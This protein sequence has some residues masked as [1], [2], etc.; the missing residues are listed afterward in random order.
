MRENE[1]ITVTEEREGS[2]E[3]H[4]AFVQVSFSR[5]QGRPGKLYG[6]NLD[7]HQ[8]YITLTISNSERNHSSSHDWY[9][10]RKPI[11]E[12]DFSAAQFAELITTLNVGSGVPA[13]L[14]YIEGRGS[15]PGLPDTVKTEAERIEDTFNKN[16]EDSV[17]QLEQYEKDIRA[18]LEKKS[19]TKKDR[20]SIKIMVSKAR[21]V[22][23]DSAPF[24]VSSMV[25]AK[26]TVV[27]SAKA[28]VES[29]MMNAI[30]KAGLKTLREESSEKLLVENNKED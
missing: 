9:F 12:V 25:E 3:K 17:S 28:E 1:D 26:E 20:E 22:F 7:N 2:V 5:R 21:R 16:L 4:P 23:T 15:V 18:L 30:T 6:S 14:R 24:A 19:L 10:G 27:Q 13:T 29:F 8:S 11:C